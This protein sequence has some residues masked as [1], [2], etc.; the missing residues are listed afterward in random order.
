MTY[1][2]SYSDCEGSTVVEKHHSFF[3]W[4]IRIVRLLRK[5]YSVL[6]YRPESEVK[7]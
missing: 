1:A 3:E 4:I 2:L 7:E 6:I 5:G